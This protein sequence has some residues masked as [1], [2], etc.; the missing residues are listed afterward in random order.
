MRL[1]IKELFAMLVVLSLGFFFTGNVMANEQPKFTLIEKS[2][3]F[4]L[5]RYEPMIVAE[6]RVQG[7]L[8]RAP[9]SD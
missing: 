9:D 5:R 8:H 1:A 6:T 7:S 4:E 2:G 3:E